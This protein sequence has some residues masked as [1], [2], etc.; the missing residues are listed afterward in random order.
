VG[1]QLAALAG[2]HMKRVT[3]EL[4][5]HAPVIVCDDADIDAAVASLAGSKFRNAGQQCNSPTRFLVQDGVYDKF[6]DA[7][8]GK[9]KA[10]K[11]ADGLEAGAQ[12]GPLANP[13]RLEAMQALVANAVKDGAQVKTGGKRLGNEGF[14]FEP[15]VLSNVTS[16]AQIMNEEPFGPVAPFQRFRTLDE[17]IREG[18]RLSYGLTAYAF[19]RSMK[20]AAR[21]GAEL[22]VGAV[23]INQ[24]GPPWPEI[25]FGGVKESGYGYE[26]GVEG[27][28]AYLTSKV[29]TQVNI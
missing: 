26:G 3:M 24:P 6:L 15:T 1:K 29:V 19:T 11:V 2:R 13:R 5:G 27:L 18:N 22:E 9:A 20:N 28:D 14:F 10:I 4:G 21:L 25:P 16:D 17:A 7:F 12:M 23:W 8:A